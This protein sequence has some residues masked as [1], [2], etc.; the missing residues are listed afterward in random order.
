MEYTITVGENVSVSVMPTQDFVKTT[1]K[2][3]ESE[4]IRDLTD[5]AG[6]Q[7]GFTDSDSCL[8]MEDLEYLH[9]T[10]EHASLTEYLAWLD[11]RTAGFLDK[12]I[13]RGASRL[14]PRVARVLRTTPLAAHA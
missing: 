13:R 7:N 12:A 10:Q 11:S 14:R 3:S 9:A 4:S 6:E 8:P 5:L 1:T 2:G